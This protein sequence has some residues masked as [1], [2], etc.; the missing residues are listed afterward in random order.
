MYYARM[1]VGVCIR[2]ARLFKSDYAGIPD[3]RRFYLFPARGRPRRT[4]K[5]YCK[6]RHLLIA[7]RSHKYGTLYII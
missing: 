2:R 6:P 5:I 3:L 1:R 4:H 7:L